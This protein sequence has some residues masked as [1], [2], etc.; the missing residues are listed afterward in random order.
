LLLRGGIFDG[1]AG[2]YYAFQRALAELMLSLHLLDHDL[3]SVLVSKTEEL[4]RGDA[5]DAE[6]A[7]SSR[8]FEIRSPKSEIR[9]S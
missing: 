3:R 9:N 5:E 6:V 4:Q 7:Q 8:Q 1:W 2:F